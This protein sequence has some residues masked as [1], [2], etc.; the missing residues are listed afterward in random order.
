MA[1]KSLSEER[2]LIVELLDG[3]RAV[4]AALVL[5][6][7]PERGRALDC[8]RRS[9][10]A[11]APGRTRNARSQPRPCARGTN[12]E[13]G[14]FIEHAAQVAPRFV[15]QVP[16]LLLRVAAILLLFQ[17][18]PVVAQ[19][20]GPNSGC[21]PD[22]S[23]AHGVVRGNDLET[24]VLFVG[25]DRANNTLALSV[26][27]TNTGGTAAYLAL[28]GPQPGAVDSGGGVYRVRR[29][30]GI[31]ACSSLSNGGIDG[32]IRN[33]L[34]GLPGTVFSLVSPGTSLLANFELS[35]SKIAKEGVVAFTMNAALGRETRPV[36]DRRED[37]GLEYINIHVPL[38]PLK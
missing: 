2:T 32:C 21:A 28:I 22:V 38:I 11:K 13:V 12:R 3:P 30:V 16:G 5:S 35:A 14:A 31:A 4:A 27:I 10:P 7:P 29:T 20:S 6:G 24:R 18:L 19:S 1:V 34:N 26:R 15:R 8:V 37:P 25:P 9:S 17:A 23:A 33:S 36:D